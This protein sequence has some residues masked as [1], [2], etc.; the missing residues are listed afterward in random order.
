MQSP[1]DDLKPLL[2]YMCSQYNDKKKTFKAQL[3]TL[4]TLLP[5]LHVHLVMSL[6]FSSSS[7]KF[8][9]L[10]LAY[11]SPRQYFLLLCALVQLFLCVVCLLM[12]NPFECKLTPVTTAMRKK[13]IRKKKKSKIRNR[14]MWASVPSWSQH[15]IFFPIQ[16]STV[17]KFIFLGLIIFCSK[18]DDFTWC[19]WNIKPKRSTCPL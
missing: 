15:H 8:E 1:Y 10:D 12:F 2:H 4:T 16:E 17:L 13:R 14:S 5:T 9:F 6:A 11:V 3:K 7:N 18:I 19:V